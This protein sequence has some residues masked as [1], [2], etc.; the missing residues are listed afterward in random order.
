[1]KNISVFAFFLLTIASYSVFSATIAAGEHHSLFLDTEGNVWA[2]GSNWNGQLGLGD[3]IQQR[4]VLVPTKID[5]VP[6]IKSVAAGYEHSLLLDTEGHTWPS[7][8]NN[9]LCS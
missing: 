2:T 7:V 4:K 3:N 6:P 1:M 8:S 9:R 5:N